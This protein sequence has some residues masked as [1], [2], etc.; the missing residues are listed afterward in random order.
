MRPPQNHVKYSSFYR[1]N[2][3]TT[4]KRCFDHVKFGI[5]HYYRPDIKILSAAALN[6]WLALFFPP[7]SLCQPLLLKVLPHS[8][9]SR[10]WLICGKLE[11]MSNKLEH[12]V[13]YFLLSVCAMRQAGGSFFT[14]CLEELIFP[15]GFCLC[16]RDDD[17]RVYC[18][19]S[20]VVP[21][22]QSVQPPITRDSLLMCLLSTEI[23]QMLFFLAFSQASITARCCF[24]Q[25]KIFQPS[26][27]Q[28]NSTFEISKKKKK[29]AFNPKLSCEVFWNHIQK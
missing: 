11:A 24:G 29:R 21:A 15:T 12:N 2:V 28:L 27:W 5:T 13:W 18:T 10:R 8:H 23:T 25:N 20:P 6:G 3:L 17:V 1:H 4:L 16:L 19:P 14:S 9:L 7:H 26:A 22:P